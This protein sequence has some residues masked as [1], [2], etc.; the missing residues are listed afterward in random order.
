MKNLVTELEI[1]HFHIHT[2]QSSW[3]ASD[4]LTDWTSFCVQNYPEYITL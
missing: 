3:Y 2:C 1:L 4:L